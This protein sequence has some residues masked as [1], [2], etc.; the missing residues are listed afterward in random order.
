MATG[1]E[2]MTLEDAEKA[3]QMM[4]L[5]ITLMAKLIYDLIKRVESLERKNDRSS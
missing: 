4:N 5:S 2:K 1:K 3:I